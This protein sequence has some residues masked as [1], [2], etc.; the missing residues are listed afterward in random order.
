MK[1]DEKIEIIKRYKKTKKEEIN[2]KTD[3]EGY[4]IG[5]WV[6][7]IRSFF[8]RGKLNFSAE[9]EKILKELGILENR[10]TRMSIDERIDELIEWNR[11]YPMM[12]ITTNVNST[13]E[14]LRQYSQDDSE[15]YELEK[16]YRRMQ[17]HY[18]YIIRSNKNGKLSSDQEEKCVRGNIGGPFLKPD[19]IGE[20]A[21]KYRIKEQKVLY[22]L[23]KYRTMEE[24]VNAIRNSKLSEQDLEQI[25]NNIQTSFCLSGINNIGI[26]KLYLDIFKK[27]NSGDLVFFDDTKIL[28]TLEGEKSGKRKIVCDNYGIKTGKK[29]KL[30]ETAD[31]NEC[32]LGNVRTIKREVL[33]RL[34]G[35]LNEAEVSISINQVL[36]TYELSDNEREQI[37]SIQK[38]IFSSNLI[39]IPDNEYADEP[40]DI[41]EKDLVEMTKIIREIV[42][43]HISKNK[44]SDSDL[45]CRLGLSNK[46][47][48]YLRSVGIA[49]VGEFRKIEVQRVLE[50]KGV[51]VGT[52]QE[53]LVKLEEIG[54]KVEIDDESDICILN[55]SVRTYKC[56]NAMGVRTVNEFKKLTREKLQKVKGIGRVSIT[57]ILEKLEELGVTIENDSD[58]SMLNLSVRAQKYLIKRGIKTVGQLK[59]IDEVD[60]EGIKEKSK[61]EIITMIARLRKSD[62]QSD[63]KVKSNE[64]EK[65]ENLQQLKIKRDIMRFQE[66]I[67]KRKMSEARQ[68]YKRYRSLTRKN[69]IVKQEKL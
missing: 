65:G 41:C 12:R 5:K 19:K 48:N 38:R 62:E 35:I 64:D 1:I 50:A 3:F 27:D 7:Q 8:N 15:Y 34:R 32:G 55:L 6:I 9:Q 36:D 2:G 4:P 69:E 25:G 14:K 63:N 52:L 13:T 37:R 45:I 53:I 18:K 60:I 57:E 22:I 40:D 31:E 51:G 46:S 20:L 28:E 16:I 61:Q 21:K 29:L 44:I 67:I 17:N 10:R 54:A 43:R 39:F 68:L 11:K 47:Y 58:I 66:D 26:T 49:T 24:F 33:Q 56:L 42:E 23:K 59:E 30:R